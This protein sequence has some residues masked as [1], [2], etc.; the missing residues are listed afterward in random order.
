M[1]N[2]QIGPPP[3]LGL[4]GGSGGSIGLT[5]LNPIPSKLNSSNNSV[6]SNNIKAVSN[7]PKLQHLQ[8][9]QQQQQQHNPGNVHS[10]YT[11]AV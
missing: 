8:Q 6:T 1:T 2:S 11:I 7:G 4:F 5:N 10:D 9:M 3:Q